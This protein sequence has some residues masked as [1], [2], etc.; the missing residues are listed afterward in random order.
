M[1]VAIL[2]ISTMSII[3][4]ASTSVLSRALIDT[5]SSIYGY[6]K[7]ITYCD[8]VGYDKKVKNELDKIDLEFFVSVITELIKENQDKEYNIPIR[9]AMYGV[10]QI[11]ENIDNELRMIKEAMDEHD[12]KYMKSW[13]NFNCKCNIQEIKLQKKILVKRYRILINLLKIYS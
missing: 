7:Y 13:R 8:K 3:S 11:L 9:N 5:T 12:K 1:E 4:A 2:G 10:N 6:I